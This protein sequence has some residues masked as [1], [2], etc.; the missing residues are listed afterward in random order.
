MLGMNELEKPVDPEEEEEEDD[1]KNSDSKNP[2]R[3]PR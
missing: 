1:T 2:S 3:K